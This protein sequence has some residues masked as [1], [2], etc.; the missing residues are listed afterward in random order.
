MQAERHEKVHVTNF[1]QASLVSL[2]NSSF[3]GSFIFCLFCLLCHF[4]FQASRSFW[5][6]VILPKHNFNVHPT[7]RET[8]VESK[9]NEFLEA[10]FNWAWNVT[11]IQLLICFTIFYSIGGTV[12][13]TLTCPLE[14]VKTR[15]QVRIFWTADDKINKNNTCFSSR[16]SRVLAFHHHVIF[17]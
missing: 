1:I 7:E 10:N 9:W 15:L 6:R 5:F 3:L 16:L 4:I 14:V 13:A 2:V 12:G 8:F 11:V 17:I